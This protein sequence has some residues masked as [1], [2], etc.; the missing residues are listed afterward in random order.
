MVDW[1]HIEEK[2]QRR[3]AESGAFE[4]DPDPERPKYYLTVA[5]PYP[6]SPQHIGH[7]RTYTLTDVHARYRRMHGYNVLLPM[8][9][10][11]T[12][13][14]LFA[15]VERLKEGDED[16]LDTFLN[17]YHIPE[18]R[19]HELE[20]PVG[21]ARYFSEEIKGGMRRMGFSIDWRRE[22]T[23]VDPYYSR[24]IEWQFERLRQRGYITQGSHPVGWCPHCGNP[25]GQHDT[26]G[27]VEPEIE[28][29]TAIK[30]TRGEEAFPA[31]TLRPET[32]FGVT[33]IWLN[34]GVEYVRARVDGETWVVSA[35][36]VEKLRFLGHEVEMEERLRGSDL[37]GERLTNP[38]TGGEIPVLPAEFVD[39]KN[40]TGVVM[41]VPAHAPYDYVALDEFKRLSNNELQ[42]LGLRPSDVRMLAPVSV[43]EL[44]GFGEVPAAVVVE[45]MGIQS[46]DDPR[47][48]DATREVYSQEFHRG[49]MRGN[50]GP[51]AGLSVGVAKEAVGSDLAGEGKAAI[52]Y[53]LIE[54]VQCRCGSDVIVKIFENQWFIDY[55][56]PA[57]K[58]LAHENLDEMA[59]VPGELRPEFDHVIDWL[60][61]KACARRAGL[62]TKLPWAPDWII[63]A[64]SDSTIYM[65][66]YTVIK[67][68]N[69]LKPEPE[70]LGVPFW[71]YV[72]LGE[73]SAEAVAGAA[74]IPVE[75][76]EALRA[77]FAYFYPLDARHSGRDLIPNHLTF[78]IFNHDGIFPRGLWPRGIVVNGSVLMEGQK[79]SKSLKNI[80]PLADAI[81]IFGADPLRLA[82]MITAEPL[83][84]ADFSRELARSMQENLEKFYAKAMEIASATD[85]DDFE[86]PD[87][88]RWM[89]SRLQRAIEEVTEAM[90]EMRVRRAIH[91]AFYNLNGDLDWYLRRTAGQRRQERR[92]R[93][94]QHV[95]RAA[96]EAQVKM[97]APFAPHLC[98]EIWEALGGEG[99]VSFAPWPGVDEAS[100]RLDAEE[101]E[102]TIR[103]SLEDVQNIIRVTGIEPSGVHF[104]TA[105]GWKWK[106]YLKALELAA[107]GVLDVGTLIRESFKDEELKARAGEVPA[108]AR[109]IIED[110]KRTPAETARRRL[111]MGVV[112]ETRLLQDASDFLEA[113][114]GCEV[115]ISGETDPWIRD[116]EKRAARAKPYRPAIYVE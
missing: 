62:G 67:G 28:E 96:L 72:F 46:Q 74:D 71:D 64:L 65:A 47:L 49:R 88:D 19:L 112:N 82:L 85:E 34:P 8:A 37:V 31:A 102:A 14:P 55:G 77:E 36:A 59:I 41:S 33:N 56:D 68:I 53:E 11:Y 43:I 107:G 4:A 115:S 114:L 7:G 40:A 97:L 104:Y 20:D 103:A 22:F 70:A 9:W 63:E 44:P 30:F 24:F 75:G 2:W 23:T 39:P 13:T 48:E 21:M 54:P 35:D 17:L 111:E 5:Y 3:W 38:A 15:M 92:S 52:I 10:H 60:K 84:D 93:A 12:G 58:R 61:R 90:E 73:G 29:F 116:P 18:D 105:T 45:K 79:M 42:K 16:L 76:L 99:L 95:L 98:E 80:I 101:M 89:M 110:A 86:P 106:V 87:I 32:V 69:E 26:V 50:T 100:I 81:D 113:E 27:D 51:Y 109:V 78:M 91:A 108:F 25:V 94:V 83:K 57:W 1:K 6:N 66:Y